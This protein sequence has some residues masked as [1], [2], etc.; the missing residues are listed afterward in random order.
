MGTETTPSN[1]AAIGSGTTPSST[2]IMTNPAKQHERPPFSSHSRPEIATASKPGNDDRKY[3]EGIQIPIVMGSI[4]TATFLVLLDTTIIATVITFSL[5]PS[6]VMLLSRLCQLTI[7]APIRQAVPKITSEFHS[8]QDISWYGSA[9]QLSR[10]DNPFVP[11]FQK[12]H[13]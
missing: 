1:L 2:S 10:W 11:S 4:V 3:I 6:P 7:V 12:I 13:H 9:F 8:L 5:G